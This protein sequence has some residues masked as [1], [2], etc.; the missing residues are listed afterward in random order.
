MGR[1]LKAH[2]LLFTVNLMYA[3]N[4]LVAK[5][6]M[7]NAILPNGFILARVTGATFLFWLVYLFNYEKI[8]RKDIGRLLLCGLFGV[9]IN[10]L[11]FFNGL[12]RTS[13]LNSSIIMTASPILVFVLSI[14]LLGEKPTRQKI[15]GISLGAIGAVAIILLSARGIGSASPIGD[16]F[17]FINACSYSLYLVIVKPL[18]E[19]YKPLTV[20]TWVFTFGLVYILFWPP[21]T[22]E[23]FLA[24]ERTWLPEELIKLAFVVIGVTFIPYLLTV[25]AMKTLS[26]SI[27]SVYIYFQPLLVSIFIVGLFYFGFSDYTND[28]TFWKF[29]A[30]ILVFIGVY[31]VSK[32][33]KVVKSIKIMN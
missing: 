12:M 7:P 15:I 29:L 27:A 17:I 30:S 14:Y 23:A 6:L 21:T 2:L 5:G 11:F 32:K 24:Y 1:N 25:T 3:I 19:K 26:P 22:Q 31:L 33:R 16:L 4:Y 8:A 20:I 13:P 28:F 18:M 10:Q 9:A